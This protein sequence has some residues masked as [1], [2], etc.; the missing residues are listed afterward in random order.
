MHDQ[1]EDCDWHVIEHPEAARILD[2]PHKSRFLHPFLE[3]EVTVSEAART[4]GVNALTMYRRVKR[5]EAHGLLHVTRTTRRAGKAINHYRAIAARFFVPFSILPNT[6]FEGEWLEQDDFWRQLLANGL[7]SVARDA[8]RDEGVFIYRAHGG[9][10]KFPSID[11]DRDTRL[12]R[13]DL[14]GDAQADLIPD[15]KLSHLSGDA[16]RMFPQ[17]ADQGDPLNGGDLIASE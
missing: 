9:I 1:T 2:D 16:G 15:E 14:G 8:M 13:R 5:L 17:N 3:H 7:A 6:D 12:A 10:R 4:L 11:L